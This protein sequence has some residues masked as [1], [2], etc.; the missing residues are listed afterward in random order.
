LEILGEKENLPALLQ[1][2]LPTRSLETR[3]RSLCK[4]PI[5]A[6]FP[7]IG[8]LTAVLKFF[9][10]VAIII[11]Y[12]LNFFQIFISK[13]RSATNGCRSLETRR[14]NVLKN[15]YFAALLIGKKKKNPTKTPKSAKIKSFVSSMTFVILTFFKFHVI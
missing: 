14:R 15:D 2:P 9:L 10:E 4:K 8:F 1:S 13:G 3:E 6:A 7:K 12:F 11:G 5:F